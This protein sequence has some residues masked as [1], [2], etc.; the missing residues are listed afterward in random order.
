[1]TQQAVPVL[2]ALS[3]KETMLFYETKLGFSGHDHGGY[4]T[5]EN[6][7]TRLHFFE[8]KDKYLCENSGCYIY[9]DN[10]E[11]LYARLSAFDIIHPDGKLESKAWGIKEF[12]VVDNNGNLLRFGEIN[13]C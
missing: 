4:A 3:I 12:C 1:M 9:T 11:D 2:P 10:I 7:G 6:N 8:C 13:E 5:M